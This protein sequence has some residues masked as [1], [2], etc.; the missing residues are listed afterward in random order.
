[1]KLPVLR[2][3]AAVNLS[4]AILFAASTAYGEPAAA[5]AAATPADITPMTTSEN[6]SLDEV[7]V[8]AQ[9]REQRIQDVPISLSVIGGGDLDKSSIQSV[10]DALGMVPGVAVNTTAQGGETRLTIRGVTAAGDLFAGPS[11]IAY[12]L[13][14]V[15][16]GLVRSAVQPDAN[17]YDL[18]RIEVLRGPQ[19]TLYGASALNGVVRV[20][21]NDADVNEF[22]F[23]ARGG[24]S[25]T[26]SGGGNY[27]SDA[28]VNVPIVDGKLAARLVVGDRHDSGWI[29]TPLQNNDNDGDVKNIRF[30]VTALPIDDL[31][32][33]LGATHEEAN[34]GAPPEGTNNYQASTQDQFIDSRFSA[35]D[36][37]IDYSLPWFTI[38]SASSYFT[39]ANNGSIDTTPGS[40]AYDPPLTTLQSSRV[41]AEEITLNSKIDGPWRWSAGGFFR[42]ASDRT[43]QTLG[44]LIPAPYDE[45]DTSRSTA[46]YGEVG[47]KFFD[48][49]FEV[50]AG[51]RYFHDDVG[52]KQL[53]LF[54]EPPGTPF[55]RT[56]DIYHAITPRVVLSWYPSHDYTMYA[57]YSEGFRS[58]FPEDELVQ[59]EAPSFPSVKPD[60]LHNYEIG[61]KGVLWDNRLSFDAAVYYMKW[62]NLQQTLGIAVAGSTAYVVAPVNGN[63]A[64]GMGVDFAATLKPIQGL[65]LGINF[66]WNGLTEDTA[67]ISSGSLLFPKGARIDDSPAYTAGATAAYDFPLV[68][69]WAGQV[70]ALARYTSLQTSTSARVGMDLPPNVQESDSITTARTSFTVIAPSHWRVML[71]S[72]NVG[73]NRGV[74]QRSLTPYESISQRP[75]TSGIQVDYQYK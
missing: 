74:P 59:L 28:A 26:T 46:I 61:G 64:S 25:T 54:G 15:P 34:Y 20:L 62:D 71:Y 23:K 44:T 33:K 22:E 10:S 16:F 37:K 9:K 66:S 57:S 55:L 17:S 12:Y 63:S 52:I 3:S 56:D 75:R 73:N 70:A 32:I 49:Q 48:D 1:M 11:A 42:N 53:I 8:T 2:F 39:F 36:A 67:V 50:T 35:Y 14:S 43:Y 4:T 29:N 5:D 18:N 65:S 40:T 68:G 72:D 69:G 51:A 60:K 24:S 6:A 47:R 45:D 19:G 27:E 30:K 58:G 21:T 41:F 38:S 7:V 13:D 31:S